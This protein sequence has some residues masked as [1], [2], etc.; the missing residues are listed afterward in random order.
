MWIGIGGV[1]AVACACA[2]AAAVAARIG[3]A[4]VP[5][6]PLAV[7]LVPSLAGSEL[8]SVDP[9]SGRVVGR[10]LLRSLATDID[11]D[12]ASGRVI[13]AQTGGLGGDADNALSMADPRTGRVTYVRLPQIDPSQVECVAGR[14]MVLHAVVDT[15]GFVASGV[16]LSSGVVVVNGNVPDGSGLWA[17]VRGSLWTSVPRDGPA[18]C[19]LVRAD[20]ATLATAPGPELDFR[21]NSMVEAGTGVAVLGGS[22]EENARVALLDGALASVTASAH[23]AGL[24]HGAQSGVEVGDAL[25]V[26]DWNGELPET[27]ALQVL[28]RETLAPRKTLRTGAAPCA[29]AAYDGDV[30]VV[31][32]VAG[33]LARID[34]ATGHVEWRARLGAKEL[35]CSGVVVLPAA[36]SGP[37]GD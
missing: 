15:R 37:A 16:D 33:T 6:G 22:D 7:V 28:D 17:A 13:A 3:A 25:V 21:P 34:P 20:P 8:V 9:D 29:V 30:L 32:R 24:P 18:R 2:A 36:P 14:A 11:V 1:I 4:P 23:V 26:G 31:D 5:P 19:A 10:V 27:G 12:P 35:L